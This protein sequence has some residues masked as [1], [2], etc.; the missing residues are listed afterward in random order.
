MFA[1]S[2][3]FLGV[4][5]SFLWLMYRRGTWPLLEARIFPLSISYSIL[6]KSECSHSLI[7][8]AF[9]VADLHCVVVRSDSW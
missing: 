3:C 5:S 8:S 6:P 2:R 4:L 9:W 7:L 1:L